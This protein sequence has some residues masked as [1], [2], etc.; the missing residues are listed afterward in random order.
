MSA[1]QIIAPWRIPEFYRR[2]RGRTDL[3]EYAEVHF[4]QVSVICTALLTMQTVLQQLDI[5]LGGV[6]VFRR[7]SSV[8]LLGP[9][10]LKL[11]CSTVRLCRGLVWVLRSLVFSLP[12]L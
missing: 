1:S 9:D 4:S 2:F 10:S 12:L 8:V 7:G 6:A 3:M 5:Q 11:G